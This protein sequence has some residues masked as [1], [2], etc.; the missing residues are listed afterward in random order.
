MAMTREHRLGDPNSMFL[1]SQQFHEIFTNLDNFKIQWW[2]H[3]V[4]MFHKGK[5]SHFQASDAI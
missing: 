5:R 1:C 3:Q 4:G 2:K